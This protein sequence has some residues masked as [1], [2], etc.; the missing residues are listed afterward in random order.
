[1]RGKEAHGVTALGT[2]GG[3]PEGGVLESVIEAGVGEDACGGVL[4]GGELGRRGTVP[5][6]N[7]LRRPVFFSW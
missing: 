3:G 2:W 6:G 1:L 5:K 4:E 7:V